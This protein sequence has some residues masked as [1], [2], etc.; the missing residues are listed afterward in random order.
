MS[1]GSF[2]YLY[3]KIE[4]E[5]I[6]DSVLD[7][8]KRMANWLAEPEQG[9]LKAANELSQL[10]GYLTA[11]RNEIIE[12]LNQPLLAV[13]KEAEWWYSNDV[14]RNSFEAVWQRYTPTRGNE[15]MV[16]IDETLFRMIAQETQ[17]DFGAGGLADE[18][19]YDFALEV[20]E[21]Y[22][23]KVSFDWTLAADQ[24]PDFGELVWAIDSEDWPYV[25]TFE[26]DG[27][28]YEQKEQ[29]EV[30][31]IWWKPVVIPKG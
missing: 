26:H 18:L 29:T 2:D 10:H 13:I 4:D 15:Q 11:V 9:Q 23:Q 27:K 20:I 6:N 31:V 24:L 21:R 22:V 17:N 25:A 7:T 1:G 5:P 28:W 3:Q 30:N 16:Y 8:L 19:Y 12:K 14:G